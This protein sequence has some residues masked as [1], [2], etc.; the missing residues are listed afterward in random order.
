ME[1][2]SASEYCPRCQVIQSTFQFTEDG[3]LLR[4]C[5]ACGFPVET[6]LTLEAASVTDQAGAREIKILCVDDDPLI[7]QML[8]DILR[9]HGYT[10][11]TAPD[12]E[13]G[14]DAALRERPD[15]VLL[16]VMMPGIDGFDVC[17]LLKTHA[18]LGTI[19]VVILTAMNDPKLN[20]RAFEAG[21]VLALQ[22]TVE[23]SAVLRT[24][25]AALALGTS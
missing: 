10:V 20:A 16:D 2:Q 1:Q 24:I 23:T 18:T 12:G 15:L 7:L 22:K 19:P 3:V 5:Q 14:L 17:R 9:F 4:R 21:A 13:A 8:G 6:G 11:V 25:E